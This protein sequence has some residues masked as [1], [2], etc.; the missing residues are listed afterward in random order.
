M[1]SSA[2][3]WGYLKTFVKEPEF[4]NPRWFTSVLD[5][6]TPTVDINV[7]NEWAA[8]YI[9]SIVIESVAGPGGQI[10]NREGELM[11]NCGRSSVLQ[12]IGFEYIVRGQE[13]QWTFNAGALTLFSLGTYLV[14]D[15][16]LI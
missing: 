14:R 6:V 15:A 5:G 11:I 10:V 4:S 1:D 12:D 16:S 9:F 3:Y 2:P 7:G 8:I 13:L